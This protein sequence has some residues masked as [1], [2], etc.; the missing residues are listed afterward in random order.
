MTLALLIS[1]MIKRA[2]RG[3]SNDAVPASWRAHEIR[4][5]AASLAFAS[6][7]PLAEVLDA[8]LLE[9]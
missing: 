7:L 5:W 6:S 8:A 1:E 2:Y 4:A 3:A 9:V